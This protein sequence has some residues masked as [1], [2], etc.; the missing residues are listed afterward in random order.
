MRR[1]I[2]LGAALGL[3]VA[4]LALAFWRLG[5]DGRSSSGSGPGDD[6]RAGDGSGEVVGIGNER[7]RRRARKRGRKK[8]TIGI[9][10]GADKKIAHGRC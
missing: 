10:L 6:V 3:A 7:Q 1:Y 4:G 9:S 8:F 2:V 5:G